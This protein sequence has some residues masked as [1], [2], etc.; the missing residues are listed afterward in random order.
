MSKA[1]KFEFK[2]SVRLLGVPPHSPSH[3]NPSITP[4][5]FIGVAALFTPHHSASRIVFYFGLRWQSLPPKRQHKAG[6]GGGGGYRGGGRGGNDRNSG[7][8][9]HY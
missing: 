3:S 2:N 4:P 9:A 6:G 1:I 5:V 7:G 8:G